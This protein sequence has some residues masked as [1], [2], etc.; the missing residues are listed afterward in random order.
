MDPTHTYQL[1]N[2]FDYLATV[3]WAISGAFFAARRGYDIPGIVTF[4]I[5]ACACGGLLRDGLFLNHG[6]IALIRDPVYIIIP[7]IAS[8]LI[9][10][11][12]RRIATMPH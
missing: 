2:W 3:L 11:F 4:S 12:G 7:L 9:W 5:L 6:P 10:R 8:L 1:P